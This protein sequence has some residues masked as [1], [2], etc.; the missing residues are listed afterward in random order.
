MVR[1]FPRIHPRTMMNLYSTIGS[2][3]FGQFRGTH[4]ITKRAICWGKRRQLKEVNDGTRRI[5]HD[6]RSSGHTQ[7]ES[8]LV[9][10]GDCDGGNMFCG[11]IKNYCRLY[12]HLSRTCCI[13]N[14][15]Q[16]NDS[17]K[18]FGDCATLNKAVNGIN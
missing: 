1:G 10:H 14:N 7:T 15:G 17:N 18:L 12:E 2:L 3:L 13:S 16:K 4:G 11:S 5:S 9:L 6:T 8:E